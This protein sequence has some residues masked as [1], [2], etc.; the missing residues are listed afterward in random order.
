MHAVI[1][2]EMREQATS[3]HMRRLR[4]GIDLIYDGVELLVHVRYSC[5]LL[6]SDATLGL[7]VG[8]CLSG[9]LKVSQTR[10]KENHDCVTIR[11]G[12]LFE[13]SEGFVCH[14]ACD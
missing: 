4:N 10:E 7:P 12:S 6:E 3:A 14:C 13:Y 9:F 1:G 2:S 8:A 5:F 11:I